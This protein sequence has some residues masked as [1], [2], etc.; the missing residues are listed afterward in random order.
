MPTISR[1]WVLL[2]HH[3]IISHFDSS[4]HFTSFHHSKF[5]FFTTTHSHRHTNLTIK[6]SYSKGKM[7]QNFHKCLR[8]GQGG[9]AVKN[10]FHDPSS[11]N[12]V[13]ISCQGFLKVF[14]GILVF[15]LSTT[16]L[17]PGYQWHPNISNISIASQYLK[18]LNGIQISQRRQ[19]EPTVRLAQKNQNAQQWYN[20]FLLL[21]PDVVA[22]P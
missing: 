7:G 20:V 6:E 13:S 19:L 8:S 16:I 11:S 5:H 10:Q 12:H 18:Y 14:P 2:L 3:H 21:L 15:H 17:H 9:L 4:L 1:M 22:S